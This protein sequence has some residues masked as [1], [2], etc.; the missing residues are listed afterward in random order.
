MHHVEA[1]E[2]NLGAPAAEVRPRIVERIAEF[3]EHVQ[4]HE[5]AKDVLTAGIINE[6]F[7]G[8]ERAAGRSASKWCR[9]DGSI[10]QSA[11]TTGTPRARRFRATRLYTL[12]I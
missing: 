7:N 9:T 11:T 1:L 5:Q 6:G 10:L 8:D 4:R 2:A 12:L 3:D